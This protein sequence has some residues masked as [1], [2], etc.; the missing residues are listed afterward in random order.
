MARKFNFVHLE[1][2]RVRIMVFNA[3]FNSISVILKL[4]PNL[5]IVKNDNARENPMS[6][7]ECTIQRQGHH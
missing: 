2:I 3:T 4:N 1:M 5:Y 7:Q 6:N